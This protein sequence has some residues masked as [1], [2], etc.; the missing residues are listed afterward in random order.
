MRLA[1]ITVNF[2]NAERTIALLESLKN[3]LVHDVRV[4][5]VDNASEPEDKNKLDAFITSTQTPNICFIAS[6][7]NNGFSAGNNLAIKQAL[8]DG[9]E[10]V[11]LINND[12]VVKADFVTKLLE[13]LSK[14]P[15]SVAGI[16][17]K[18]GEHIAYAGL[19]K[20]FSIT[21]PHIYSLAEARR[22]SSN[23]YAI[24]GGVAFH[25][26]SLAD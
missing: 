14:I 21:L 10:W 6:P 8:S 15:P 17:L 7:K 12:T 18:E 24:G 19:V 16:P 26:F 1:I 9:A 11:T 22:R 4:Y 25:R 13:E 23:V 20:W 3:Q 2:N 5:V